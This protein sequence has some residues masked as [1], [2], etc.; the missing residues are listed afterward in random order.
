[1]YI[2]E[3]VQFVL[4]DESTGKILVLTIA[5]TFDHNPDWLCSCYFCVPK[6]ICYLFS[7]NIS[8]LNIAAMTHNDSY[9]VSQFALSGVF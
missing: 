6:T 1:M 3:K 8:F 5:E 2:F 7:K 4:L 9:Q